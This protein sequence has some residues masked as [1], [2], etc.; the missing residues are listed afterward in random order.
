MEEKW[1]TEQRHR[2]FSVTKL[3]ARLESVRRENDRLQS[4]LGTLNAER[5]GV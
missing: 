2:R 3:V 5:P 4:E 1:C